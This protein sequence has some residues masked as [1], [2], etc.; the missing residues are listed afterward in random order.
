MEKLI[1][2]IRVENFS[3]LSRKEQDNTSNN[4]SGKEYANYLRV[5]FNDQTIALKSDAMEP[6]DVKFSRD[7]SWIP[8]LLRQVYNLGRL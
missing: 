6:E 7:L 1:L 3:Q 5:K 2:E 8:E 4:G